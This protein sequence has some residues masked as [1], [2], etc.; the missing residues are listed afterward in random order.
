MFCLCK[1]ITQVYL[2]YIV[3]SLR[4][5]M[6]L[7]NSGSGISIMKEYASSGIPPINPTVPSSY[8]ILA[9][10]SYC[11]LGALHSLIL[12]CARKPAKTNSFWFRG[13][14][15]QDYDPRRKSC[16]PSPQVID[17]KRQLHIHV[18]NQSKTIRGH[19]NYDHVT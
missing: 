6:T 18:E 8:R 1:T 5:M 13:T 19:S 7:H 11:Q 10:P 4:P 16:L 9:K 14:P 17:D 3:K 15:T 12:F 2:P